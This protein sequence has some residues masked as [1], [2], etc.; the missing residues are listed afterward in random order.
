MLLVLLKRE[1]GFES[2]ICTVESPLGLYSSFQVSCKR[3]ESLSNFGV[4][5]DSALQENIEKF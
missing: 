1:G 4:S 3:S 5:R 2:L